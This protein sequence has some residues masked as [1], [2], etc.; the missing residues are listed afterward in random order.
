MS[1]A[2]EAGPRT[3]GG[4]QRLE[5][6]LTTAEQMFYDKGYRAISIRDLAGAVGIQMSSLYYYFP[7]KDDI[8]YRIIKRHLDDL[9]EETG[10]AIDELP[11]GTSATQRLQTLLHVS[12]CVLLEDRL[13]GGVATA[14]TRDLGDAQRA[15]LRL[16]SLEYENRYKTV[17]RDGIESGEFIRFDVSMAVLLMLGALS[18]LNQ[19]YR[20]LG[21]LNP[22]QIACEFELMLMRGVLKPPS[23]E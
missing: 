19:W 16:L 23:S 14:H 20:P 2:K 11:A 15:E 4:D 21:R 18:R 13:A 7:S 22:E 9:L 3:M 5:L 6:I 1:T 17:L 12:T 10:K 8:L